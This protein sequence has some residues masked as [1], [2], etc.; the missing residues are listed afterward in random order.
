MES[1][2]KT[3]WKL[4]LCY[5]S[6]GLV[7]WGMNLAW[8]RIAFIS[9]VLT[10]SWS[11]WQICSARMEHFHTKLLFLPSPICTMDFQS[12]L[13]FRL[14]SVCYEE[15]SQKLYHRW[16][17]FGWEKYP[18]F[19]HAHVHWFNLTP[20]LLVSFFQSSLF[21]SLALHQTKLGFLFFFLVFSFLL[22]AVLLFFLSCSLSCHWESFVPYNTSISL[23]FSI[24]LKYL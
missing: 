21:L 5:T 16:I 24:P 6:S 22:A 23:L 10:V 15:Q 20:N 17:Y 11:R 12:K 19:Q 8:K 9:H 14:F 4:N 7:L 3:K 13:R 2:T 1:W 18:K